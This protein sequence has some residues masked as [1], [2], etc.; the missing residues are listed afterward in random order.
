MDG[1]AGM[2]WDLGR[3]CIIVLLTRELRSRVPC[4]KGRAEI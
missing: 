2:E 3:V 4:W 1:R